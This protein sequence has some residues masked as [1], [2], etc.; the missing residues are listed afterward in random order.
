M[1]ERPQSKEWYGL[2]V[3]AVDAVAITTMGIGYEESAVLVP[4][5]AAYGL[6]APLVHLGHGN[7]GGAALSLGIRALAGYGAI[8]AV[9]GGCKDTQGKGPDDC[10]EGVKHGLMILGLASVIDAALLASAVPAPPRADTER[11]R[12][13]REPSSR[14]SSLRVVPSLGAAPNALFLGASG[15][16]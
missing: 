4:A 5:F 11:D 12:P 15:T 8:V 10:S 6:G 7:A 14:F 9:P 2:Q 13:R 3:L 1:P 16:F